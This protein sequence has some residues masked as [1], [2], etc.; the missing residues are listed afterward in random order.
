M[1]QKIFE[2]AQGI[3]AVAS[4]LAF[5]G[6]GIWFFAADESR[7]ALAKF[8]GA[9]EQRD[10]FAQSIASLQKLDQ[11]IESIEVRLEA[12]DPK[13]RI[14]EI[15]MLRSFVQGVCPTEGNCYYTLRARRTILG[16]FCGAPIAERYVIDSAGVTHPVSVSGPTETAN[17]G[18]DWTQ[19][20]GIFILPDRVPAGKSEFYIRLTYAGCTP[21]KPD[22]TVVEITPKVS[23]EVIRKLP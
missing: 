3:L 1:L 19:V 10:F 15:D 21:D 5:L 11:R 8:T 6:G 17:V 18:V 12:I 14:F 9:A 7:D 23:F 16:S 4:I 22:R 20:E 2:Y 13:N